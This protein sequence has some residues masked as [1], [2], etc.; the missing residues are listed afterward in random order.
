MI[1]N[2]TVNGCF[3]NKNVLI[4]GG[5]S[6]IGKATAKRIMAEGGR[7]II[8]GTNVDK[9][10]ATKQELPGVIICVNDASDAAE[11]EKLGEFA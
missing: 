6:G 1:N 10:N 7:V 4:T 5:S 3:T 11:A 8:T 2:I 9:L